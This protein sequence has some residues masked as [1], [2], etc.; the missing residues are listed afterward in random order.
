MPN[1]VTCDKK[2]TANFEKKNNVSFC[3]KAMEGCGLQ[4]QNIA[5]NLRS[6]SHS[7]EYFVIS[8][9]LLQNDSFASDEN[10]VAMSG[11]GFGFEIAG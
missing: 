3:W 6:M 9:T 1:Q 7:N 8:S 5:E 2:E 11:A 10:V 4:F